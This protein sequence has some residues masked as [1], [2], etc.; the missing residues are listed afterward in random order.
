MGVQQV[1]ASPSRTP[2]EEAFSGFL[3]SHTAPQLYFSSL[4]PVLKN[5]LSPVADQSVESSPFSALGNPGFLK[6]KSNRQRALHDQIP[7]QDFLMPWVPS[8]TMP[9]LGEVYALFAYVVF[10][11]NTTVWL[12]QANIQPQDVILMDAI[13]VQLTTHSDL[14]CVKKRKQIYKTLLFYHSSGDLPH[15][16]AA[17]KKKKKKILFYSAANMNLEKHSKWTIAQ[18]IP[19]VIFQST[20]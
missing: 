15:L 1:C 7:Q 8:R 16:Q 2:A 3:F 5:G 9:Q 10:N 13:T 4:L 14:I 11:F 19:G 17:E 6:L 20:N 12:S 18:N